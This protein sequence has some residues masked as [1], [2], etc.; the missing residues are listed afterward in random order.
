MKNHWIFA[1]VTLAIL[2]TG[3]IYLNDVNQ[4]NP[5]K[6]IGNQTQPN[7]TQNSGEVQNALVVKANETPTREI[8][9]DII[10]TTQII[11]KTVEDEKPLLNISDTKQDTNPVENINAS[12]NYPRLS[13]AQ[14]ISNRPY[15]LSLIIHQENQYNLMII[16]GEVYN[17]SPAV[18]VSSNGGYSWIKTLG[19]AS[20]AVHSIE[21]DPSNPN[22]VY[23]GTSF[24]SETGT[25]TGK[26]YKSTNFGM[27]WGEI[28]TFPGEGVNV[29][30]IDNNISNKIYAV[31]RTGN[32]NL[33]DS[34]VHIS[35]NGG[36]N[37]TFYSFRLSRTIL[38]WA[39]SQNI[40]NGYIFLSGEYNNKTHPYNPPILRS[41]DHG[42]TWEN[43]FPSNP[44]H[45]YSIVIDERNNIIY[46][47]EEGYNLYKSADNGNSIELLNSTTAAAGNIMAF[48][49]AFDNIN[50][51]LVLGEMLFP[52]CINTPSPECSDSGRLLVS[53]NESSTFQ[54]VRNDSLNIVDLDFTRDYNKLYVSTY[55]QG[56]YV[57]KKETN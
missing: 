23:A 17:S 19:N 44:W 55:G 42:I 27:N 50:S 21:A 28:A 56:I 40:N 57:L 39:F 4:Q 16:E 36:T 7:T 3:C 11:N 54:P 52:S 1:L 43:I 46:F 47:H 51:A 32:I 5:L 38:V 22:I 49:M 8:A 12:F 45:I 33:G 14:K 41:R 37:W 10:S 13:I 26:I 34:G 48:V 31:Q 15:V 18:Y 53:I 35:N 6:Q 24:E 25:V 20:L 2:F 29:I 9:S 30:A